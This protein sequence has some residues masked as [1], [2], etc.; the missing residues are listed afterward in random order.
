M[1]K[2][3]NR[4]LQELNLSHN[5]IN[6][7]IIERVKDSI[8]WSKNLTIL[9]LSYNDILGKNISNLQYLFEMKSNWK[10]LEIS[11][12]Y[13]LYIDKNNLIYNY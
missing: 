2:I 3:N 9:D 10:T 11:G 6:D 1:F 7:E 4:K 13:G 12:N 5:S 8:I